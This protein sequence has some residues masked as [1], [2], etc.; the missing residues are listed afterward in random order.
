M[1]IK[2]TDPTNLPD[3]NNVVKLINKTKDNDARTK[4]YLN[5]NVTFQRPIIDID[6]TLSQ[7]ERLNLKKMTRNNLLNGEMVEI[8][9]ES[10][11]AERIQ[12]ELNYN[13]PRQKKTSILCVGTRRSSQ[14]TDHEIHD[15]VREKVTYEIQKITDRNDIN[16]TKSDVKWNMLTSLKKKFQKPSSVYIAD[17]K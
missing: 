6:N 5:D 10:G 15:N 2:I 17:D 12:K 11:N 13:I 9:V 4:K 3:A 8:V 14:R 1:L 16:K 7:C